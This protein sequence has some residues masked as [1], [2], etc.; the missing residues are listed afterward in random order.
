MRSQYEVSALYYL[1]HGDRRAAAAA[2]DL[3]QRT[4]KS[5]AL[6]QRLRAALGDDLEVTTAVPVRPL[7]EVGPNPP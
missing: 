7:L 6:A 2:L 3:A 1:S 4:A 5:T